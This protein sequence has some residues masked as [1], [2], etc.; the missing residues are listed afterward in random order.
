LDEILAD[1]VETGDIGRA[2]HS[3]LKRSHA[4]K[5]DCSRLITLSKKYEED[6]S[7]LRRVLTSH[8]QQTVAWPALEQALAAYISPDAD[9]AEAIA[10]PSSP[11]A[12]ANVY[13]SY[14]WGD[15]DS[16]EGQQRG[17]LVDQLC[18]AIKAAGIPF[19][20]DREE[21]KFG[22]RISAF[23]DAITKGDGIIIILSQKYLES[24]YC[25]HELT[26]IWNE[27]RRDPER[28]L[29]R[30]IPLT[31]PDARLNSTEDL[32]KTIQYWSK[33]WQRLD[34]QMRPIL[35]HVAP[36]TFAKSKMIQDFAQQIG[37]ILPLLTDKCEPR[38]FE[39]QAQEKFREV[40]KQIL[41][42]RPQ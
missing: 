1:L 4:L 3:H 19:H 42:I 20:I 37:S 24:E 21:V 32:I 38:D 27:N 22:D 11:G 7:C 12:V 39:E 17:R 23:M 41:A 14:A 18:E 36:E 13:I 33:C 6:L 15:D 34:Q 31:L 35:S 25:M 30:V 16:P 5:T 28:F 40:I 8:L 29:Q 26:G 9:D 2:I 10:C